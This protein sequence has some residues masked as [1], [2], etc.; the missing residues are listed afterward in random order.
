MKHLHLL[1]VLTFISTLSFASNKLQQFKV[2]NKSEITHQIIC[3]VTVTVTNSANYFCDN[4]QSTTTVSCTT[5]ATATEVNCSD[6]ANDATKA[7]EQE[8]YGCIETSLVGAMVECENAPPV[9]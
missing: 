8:N 5:Q 1:I 2:V 3:T 9:Q 6:A 4:T 7:A